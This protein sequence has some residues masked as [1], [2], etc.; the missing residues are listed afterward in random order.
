MRLIKFTTLLITCIAAVLSAHGQTLLDNYDA[1]GTLTYTAEANWG[2]S[3][4]NSR[5]VEN[6]GQLEGQNNSSTTPEH[7][8][9]SYDLTG[10]ISG[11]NLN[12]ANGNSWFGWM[13]LN[14]TS[15]S[16]WA[17]SNY[18]C[19]MILAADNADFNASTTTGVGVGLNSSGVLVIFRFSAGITS[20]TAALP[21]TSTTIATSGYTYAD[22][23][24][25]V[26][27]FVK[28]LSDGKWKIFYKT[29]AKLSDANAVDSAQYNT[30]NTT[31]AAVDTTYK[32]STYK[33]AGWVYAH[34][35]GA[36]QLAYFDNFGAGQNPG[37]SAASDILNAQGEANNILYINKTSASITTTSDAFK[38]WSFTI[39]DGGSTTDADAVGTILQAVTISKGGSNTVSSWTNTIKQAA[40]FD[41]S[42]KITEVSVTGETIAFSG[43][44][45][46]NVTAADGGTKTL[47]LYITFETSNLT[48]NQQFQFAIT[49]SNVTAASAGSSFTSFTT[50]NSGTGN[51][52][53]RIEITASKLNF[54]TQPS[55]T[56]ISAS[57]SPAVTVEAADANNQ[58]DLDYTANIRITSSGSLTGTPIS[59]AASSGLASFGSLQHNVVATG[60]TLNAERDTTLDWDVTSSSFN[61]TGNALSD[62][63]RD[64]S[65]TPTSD[66]DYT[67]Y[68][69]STITNTSHSIAVYK[70][71]IRDGGSSSPDADNVPTILKTI[72][73]NNII[74]INNIRSAAIFFGNSMINNSPV[75]N[76]AAGTIAFSGLTDSCADNGTRAL[77]LRVSFENSSDSITDNQ[78]MRFIITNANVTAATSGTSS[79]TAFNNDTSLLTSNINRIEA[80]GNQIAF[81]TQPANGSLGVNLT[82]FTVKV[83]DTFGVTDLDNAS[84]AT[85]STTGTGMT[86]SASYSL[87]SGSVS[88]SDVQFSASQSN[89]QIIATT[90]GLSFDNDDTSTTFSISSVA[91]NSYRTATGGTWLGGSP[92]STWERFVGG[93]W[94]S[95]SAPASNTSNEVYIRHTITTGAA[96][97]NNIKLVIESGDTFNVNHNGTIDSV[98]VKSGGVFKVNASFTMASRSGSS[99]NLVVASGGAMVINSSAIDNTSAMWNANE[100]F[101]S[102]S[103]VV[104]NDWSWGSGSGANRLLA[105]TRQIKTNSAGYHFGHLSI[106]AAP[107]AIFVLVNGSSTDSLCQGNLTVS[108]TSSNIA[109]TTSAALVTVGGNVIVN[110]GQL[111]IASTTT[112]N[113]VTTIIGSLQINNSAV[114]DMNQSSSG[115]ALSTIYLKGNLEINN[116][117]TIKCSDADDSLIF[118]GTDTQYVD[119]ASSASNIST[120]VDYFVRSGAYV[121]LRNNDMKVAGNSDIMVMTGGTLD[122]GFTSG[123]TPLNMTKSASTAT[124]TQQSGA[125]LKITSTEGIDKDGTQLVGNV[126]VDTRTFNA[127]GIYHYAG[128]ASQQRV[129][130]GLIT[131][132][133]AK[134]VIVE[135]DALSTTLLMEGF[136]GTSNVTT[137]NNTIATGGKLEIRQ[138]TIAAT[139]SADFIGAG[140]LTMSGGLYQTNVDQATSNVPQ[141]SGTYSLTGG[142]IELNGSNIA[143]RLRGGKAYYKLT[144]SG[145]NT[146]GSNNKTISSSITVSNLLTISS[147]GI[148]DPTSSGVSG[149]GNVTMTGGRFR[150]S[151][152][153]NAQPELTGT[154]SLSAGT[155]EL[156]GTSAAQTQTLRSS[157]A[158]SDTIHFFNLELNASAANATNS[159]NVNPNGNIKIN[160]SFLINS[161][162]VLHLDA[163][164]VVNGN[165]ATTLASGAGLFYGH[166]SGITSSGSQGQ[167]QTTGTRTYSKTAA[168]GFIGSGNMSGGAGLPDSVASLVIDKTVATNTVTLATKVVV[169]DSA[170]FRSGILLGSASPVLSF[171][172]NATVGSTSLSSYCSGAVQK[173]GDDAFVFPIGNSSTGYQALAISAPDDANDIFTAEY[174]RSSPLALQGAYPPT[175]HHISFCEY[176]QLTE[177]ADAGSATSINLTLYFNDSSGCSLKK[178]TGY[179]NSLTNLHVVHF[180]GSSWD[181]LGNAATSGNDDIGSITVNGVSSFSPFAFGSTQPEAINPLPIGWLEVTARRNDAKTSS[182]LWRTA[183]QQPNTAF[184]IEKSSDQYLWTSIGS[185]SAQ[186]GHSA[187][188]VYKFIDTKTG[189][190]ACYYR[191][192]SMELDGSISYSPVASLQ[193]NESR[194]LQVYPVPCSDILNLSFTQ[195]HQIVGIRVCDFAGK[196]YTLPN[197][198]RG[199]QLMQI[200][201][202]ELPRGNYV[203]EVITNH[204]VMRQVIQKQ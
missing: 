39:R 169:R 56:A 33:Y 135:L 164:D 43:M 36:G 85:L 183:N 29:G 59:A 7:S 68:Q 19:G 74:G 40:L 182:I 21:G 137:G 163:T 50:Q 196:I 71:I 148:F 123:G 16:G 143:Q 38:V 122:F 22:A 191:I 129:G 87:V 37:N 124:F 201:T 45:G 200:N 67:Q 6:S 195:F 105:T 20:A 57:I 158:T 3:G 159:G 110:T 131:T 107:S 64:V 167:I 138:G 99:T 108:T 27:F 30:G 66:I 61:I 170:A 134:T 171:R 184:T 192:R 142:T 126:R 63:I 72:T 157:T 180:N 189:D 130:D 174:M 89:I 13:D 32:G 136:N 11:W 133:G 90:T 55:N 17:A 113:P 175:I 52:T 77:T 18:S 92:T 146:L 186:A 65:H 140:D 109:F 82:A 165:A 190:A 51:D 156:Y 101:Q 28:Q 177:D 168:Y 84:V 144:I 100:D 120:T 14:R 161:P 197:T 35:S 127:A 4:S 104:V 202:S 153:T 118:A 26:N 48:D 53:N 47:D 181:D 121:K 150:I 9:A 41:G 119:F 94:S 179:I 106:S 162:C 178:D 86:S 69:A 117:A 172:D 34:S 145:S 60:I 8:Y 187:T 155:V 44:S 188:D 62:V 152:V 96:F 2:A 199:G 160:N 75:I 88:I 204:E 185:V 97:G 95:S 76:S 115:S 194:D 141:L 147:T 139:T 24:N 81:G 93:T 49:N 176:W 5:W 98:Y 203:L 103:T 25:G 23:D 111:S 10:T 132:S 15:A 79:F 1:S 58:R 42:T 102:G 73:F 31:S 166:T 70:F 46:S 149:S 128:R 91:S 125:T 80:T 112:G 54:V 154:Y 12:R 173:A 193:S 116:T 78:Q 151:K 114:V 198:Q 83:V